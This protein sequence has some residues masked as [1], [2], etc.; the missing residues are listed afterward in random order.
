M[1]M[2]AH[3]HQVASLLL[4]PLDDLV[5]RF[6]VGEFGLRGNANGL[7]LGANLFEIGG[8][9]GDL[10][11]D[12]VRAIG[13]GGPSVGH[14]QQD[15]TAVREFGQLFYVFDD[16][17]VGGG[18]VEGYENGLIHDGDPCAASGRV[19][20]L[21]DS[22]GLFSRHPGLTPLRQAQG[23]LWANEFRRSAAGAASYSAAHIAAGKKVWVKISVVPPG[24][25][26][27]PLYPALKRWAMGGR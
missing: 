25:G 12:C 5:G 1:A 4:D 14:M 16:G 8:V 2:S 10:R 24:L 21:R 18:A 9:F 19:A 11:A 26:L 13:S 22:C 6:T 3:R 20:S 15:Q 23:R 17:A 7:E 27:F